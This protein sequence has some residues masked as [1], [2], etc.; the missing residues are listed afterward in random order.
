MYIMLFD[1]IVPRVV[2]RYVSR[3]N[4]T[5]GRT[6]RVIGHYDTLLALLLYILYIMIP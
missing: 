4:D 3:C 6:D 1:V 2:L 5:R